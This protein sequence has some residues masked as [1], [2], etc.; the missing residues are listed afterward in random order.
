[1]NCFLL[2]GVCSYGCLK[3]NSA[4]FCSL[5]FTGNASIAS[6]G[7]DTKETRL[8]CMVWYRHMYKRNMVYKSFMPFWVLIAPEDCSTVF[9]H[10]GRSRKHFRN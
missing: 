10:K 5:L 2:G 7:I 6:K 3:S 8:N 1:M 9:Y 4:N